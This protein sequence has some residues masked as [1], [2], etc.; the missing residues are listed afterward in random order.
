MEK[1]IDE[2]RNRLL[3]NKELSE[4]DMTEFVGLF[5]E[6]GISVMS[7]E[8]II[9][10]LMNTAPSSS[11]VI[12]SEFISPEAVSKKSYDV[13]DDNHKKMLYKVTEKEKEIQ[14]LVKETGTLKRQRAILLI[15]SAILSLLLLFVWIN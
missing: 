14:K 1:T 9:N 2:I 10:H 13:L 3:K 8:V 12:E 5:R 15:I 6:K 7:L 4:K 11:D